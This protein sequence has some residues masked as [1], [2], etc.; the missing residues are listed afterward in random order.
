MALIDWLTFRFKSKVSVGSPLQNSQVFTGTY[1]DTGQNITPQISLTCSTVHSCVQ[2]ISTEIAKLPWSVFSHANGT[3][4]IARDHP[5]HKLICHSPNEECSALV[6]RE[7]MLMSACLTGNGFSLIERGGD[8][9]PTAL[10]YLRPDLMQVF[11]TGDGQIVYIYSGGDGVQTYDSYSIFHLMGISSDGVLG[12]SPISLARQAIGLALA[13]ETY[14]AAYYRN[15]SR[16]SGALQTDKELSPEAL[17]RLRESWES[18][19]KGVQSAGSVAVFEGGLKWQPIS[20]SPEDSQWLQSREFQR[21]EI[22][23]I[24]RVPPS[25]IGIGQKQSYASAEQ[26]NQQWVSGCLSSWAARLESEAYRKLLRADEDFS[27]EI[28]FDPMLKTDLMTRYQT[29]SVARQFGW[30]SVNEIRAELGRNS[31]GAEG[32]VYLQPTNMVPTSNGAGGANVSPTDGGAPPA[33]VAPAAPIH[34]PQEEPDAV[35]DEPSNKYAKRSRK[36]K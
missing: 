14:G 26:A 24:F 13:A 33:G 29:F 15:A 9:R 27:T 1:S 6:W 36:K 31:I 20:L 4:Q 32:D 5:V 7:L 28:S 21:E 18:R 25:V 35:P 10:H 2:A 19:M 34:S 22:C 12:Y 16:P 3:R 8:G 11:R 17:Q 30:L 23:S